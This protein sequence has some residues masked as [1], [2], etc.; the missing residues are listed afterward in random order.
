MIEVIIPVHNRCAVTL[1]CLELLAKQSNVE[2]E[3]TVI[4]DGSSDGTSEA[5]RERFP[6]VDVL[7]GD[8]LLWWAGATNLGIRHALARQR[9]V[10][11]LLMLNDDVEFN[12]D[13]LSSMERDAVAH[14]KSLIGSLAVYGEDH[15]R[16]FWCGQAASYRQCRYGYVRRDGLAGCVAAEA[17][18]GRGMLVPTDVFRR[19]GLFDEKAFPQYAAD[20]DFSLRARK[21]GYELLCCCDTAVVVSTS[22]TG[23]GSVYRSDPFNVFLRSFWHVRSPNY[24]PALWRFWTRHYGVI[25][26]AQ[27]IGKVIIGDLLRRIGLRRK[28]LEYEISGHSQRSS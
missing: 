27:Q 8:G 16:V 4:D 9:P 28:H 21:A 22:Q 5:I 13:Y 18:P 10:P 26:F 6:T 12:S 19:I 15:G 14:P 1:R 23:P 2:F 11:Y 25:P 20:F 7:R 3:V 17:L 24:L